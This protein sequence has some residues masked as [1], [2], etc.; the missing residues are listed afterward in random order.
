MNRWSTLGLALAVLVGLLV[1]RDYLSVPPDPGVDCGVDNIMEMQIAHA[2][3][4]GN[5]VSEGSFWAA[6]AAAAVTWLAFYLQIWHTTLGTK[7]SLARLVTS[8]VLGILFGWR[9]LATAAAWA[10]QQKQSCLANALAD[11]GLTRQHVAYSS[12]VLPLGWEN[13]AR[14]DLLLLCVIAVALGYVTY[15]VASRVFSL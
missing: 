6:V 11:P 7:G 2:R 3:A 8:L 1:L 10:T 14:V 4:F 13:A 5:W 12:L 9:A 15:R